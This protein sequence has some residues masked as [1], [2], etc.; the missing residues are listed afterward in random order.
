MILNSRSAS[1]WLS[2][3]VGSSMTKMRPGGV[4]SSTKVEAI[5]TMRRSPT[6]RR[7][8]NGLGRDVGDAEGGERGAGALVQRPPV[9]EA[10]ETRRIGAAEVEVLGDAEPRQH[11]QFLVQ[12]PETE[13]MRV[14]RARDRDRPAVEGDRS[15]VGRDDAGEDPDE[16]ALAGAVFAHQR[17]NFAR[18]ERK[19]RI[20]ERSCP[21]VGFGEARQRKQAQ[22]GPSVRW[23]RRSPKATLLLHRSPR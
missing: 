6:G 16:R 17:V 19:R 15:A 14:A 10:A 21:A 3:A 11:V 23:A 4:P 18:L 2:A 1:A 12:E 7:A 20:P 13:P 22:D 9:D 5:L 8:E